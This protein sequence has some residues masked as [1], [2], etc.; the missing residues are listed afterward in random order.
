VSARASIAL[1]DNVGALVDG[2]TV[3]LVVDGTIFNR[4]IGGRDI[5]AITTKHIYS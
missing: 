4:K 3:I 1:E 2:N 5:E